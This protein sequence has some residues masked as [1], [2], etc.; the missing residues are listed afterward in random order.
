MKKKWCFLLLVVL[1][2]TLAFSVTAFADG[3]ATATIGTDVYSSLQEALTN[4]VDGDTIVLSAGTF[5]ATGNEQFR[6]TQNNLIIQGQGTDTII[7]AGAWSVSG[8]AGLMVQGNGVVISN[9][10]IRSAA[11]DKVNGLKFT[12]LDAGMITSATVSN[13]TISSQGNALNLHGVETANVDGLHVTS[14]GKCGMSIAN[15]P[16]VTL[17]NSTFA[18]TNWADVGM[19]YAASDDYLNPSNLT[20]G[21]GNQFSNAKSYIYSERTSA[22]NGGVDGI[23][24]TEDSGLVMVPDASGVWAVVSAD[25][26]A[27]PVLNTTSNLHFASIDAAQSVANS[28]ETLKLLDNVQVDSMLNITTD[29]IILDLGGKSITASEN[30]VYQEN[31]ANACHLVNVEADGVQIQ[32]GS[33]VATNNN[34]HTLN[35]YGASGVT[36]SN[37]T[38]D[39]TSGRTGAPLVVNG[40]G[41]TMTGAMNLVTGANSWYGMNV[42]SKVI[43]GQTLGSSV[44]VADGAA[45][46]FSGTNPLGIYLENNSAVPTENLS[47]SF[48]SG[49]TVSG[50]SADFVAV[51]VKKD[52]ATG[53]EADVTINNPENAGLQEDE[54]GNLTPHVHVFGEWKSDETAHWKECECGEKS[55]YAAHTEELTNAKEATC[56]AEGYTGDKVCSVCSRVLEEGKVIE[57]TAHQ[58]E[59]GKC[60]VCGAADPNASGTP[61][62][63]QPVEAPEIIKGAG[64]SW[65]KGTKDGLSFT[66]DAAF[67]DF[68]KVMVDGKDLDAANY[69]VAEGSTIVTL[70][71]SYLETLSAGKH[72]LAIVSQNGTAE[73]TFTVTA[74]GQQTGT[75]P[76]TGDSNEILLWASVMLAAFGCACGVLSFEKR[77]E[78]GR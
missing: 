27:A 20:L 56:T 78:T 64:S 17:T 38:I 53:E 59:N 65:K 69:T 70:K 1:M 26:V 42:D 58:Y 71:A 6:V 21:A 28:G 4:A 43:G 77:K 29:G 34:K 18:G 12:N 63:P 3:E 49:V 35:V 76:Q 10:T 41:V 73:A 8:Q 72:R 66:S 7:D 40:S 30:F 19:M 2:L 16:S 5:S 75:K 54:N 60:T 61:D 33:L 13:V 11:G 74:T 31:N 62:D 47:V 45:L 46:S 39:H 15:T 50:S 37:L 36:I 44:T 48:G 9:L 22:A 23:Q 32:N 52:E 55:E 24:A 68:V 57:K 25:T 67:A 14:A 51:A